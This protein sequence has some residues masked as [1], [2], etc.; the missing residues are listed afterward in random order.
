MIDSAPEDRELIDRYLN[1]DRAAFCRLVE[2]HQDLVYNLC[3]RTVG[4]VEEAEDLTQ[5]IFIRLLDKLEQWRGDA[6]FTTWL[7]RLALNHCRD[8]LRRKRPETI[9]PP[10]SPADLMLGPE[11]QAEAHDFRDRVQAALMT[12]TPD[13]RAV[14]FLRDIEGFSY[15]EIAGILEIELGTVKSRLA[16]ARLALADALIMEQIGPKE[17]QR[18]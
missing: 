8:Y 2:R 13:W 7:Y 10:D 17:H 16:R 6:K 12:L 9:E 14:V 18:G 5:E 15:G 3:R 1:G 4:V 11:M